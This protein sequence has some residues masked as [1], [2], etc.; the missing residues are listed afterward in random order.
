MFPPRLQHLADSLAELAEALLRPEELL[1]RVDAEQHLEH[2]HRQP[3]RN[4]RARRAGVA[5]ARPQHCVSP[6]GGG[7]PIASTPLAHLRD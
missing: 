1:E 6:V 5:A 3:L 4:P 2:P 7:R